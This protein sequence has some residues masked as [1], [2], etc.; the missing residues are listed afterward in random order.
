[1]SLSVCVC[2]C[3]GQRGKLSMCFIS[4]QEGCD[5]VKWWMW[6]TSRRAGHKKQ[7]ILPAPLWSSPWNDSHTHTHT[8]HNHAL[9]QTKIFPF[10]CR[11]LSWYF[12]LFGSQT[13]CS[14][15]N[16]LCCG[17]SRNGHYHPWISGRGLHTVESHERG[18]GRR[19][20]QTV[21]QDLK[22]KKMGGRGMK[23]KKMAERAGYIFSS[24]YYS[25]VLPQRLWWWRI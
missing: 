20:E 1:M 18:S 10:L 16:G 14:S 5:R 6:E 12:P 19:K 3:W 22:K 2:V 15:S 24:S 11:S 9:F 23:R 25:K 7:D 13:G 8:K 17:S 4:Q 21:G